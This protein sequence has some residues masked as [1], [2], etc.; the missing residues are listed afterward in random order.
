MPTAGK[1][2]ATRQQGGFGPLLG[3]FITLL[4][5][6]F[7]LDVVL[8]PADEV[9]VP[10]EVVGDGL[11]L[12]ISIVGILLANRGSGTGRQIGRG[13]ALRGSR[14]GVLGLRR[15][16]RGVGGMGVGIIVAVWL[17][18]V[19]VIAV[20]WW[21]N[22]QHPILMLLTLPFEW[23]FDIFGILFALVVTILVLAGSHANQSGREVG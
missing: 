22:G 18:F 9:L 2:A 15:S 12:V 23:A 5:I 11:F 3:L 4:I 13:K 7:V 8:F 19:A 1:S 14:R 10:A 20:E 6:E 16:R 17:L 21:W